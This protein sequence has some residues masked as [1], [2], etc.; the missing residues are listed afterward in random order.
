MYILFLDKTVH[1]FC[2]V[3]IIVLIFFFVAVFF[4][5]HFQSKLDYKCFEDRDVVLLFFFNHTSQ[6]LHNFLSCSK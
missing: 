1:S 3:F 2:S 5:F 4:D 6:F